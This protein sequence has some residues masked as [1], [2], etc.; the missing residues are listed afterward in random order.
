MNH[1]NCKNDLFCEGQGKDHCSYFEPTDEF[2]NEKT[3][4]QCDNFASCIGKGKRRI[5]WAC[6]NF[7][8]L[9]GDF[10]KDESG[11]G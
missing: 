4:G 10:E 3:C 7:F 6:E 2:L 9:L 11:R 8:P 1:P 5:D